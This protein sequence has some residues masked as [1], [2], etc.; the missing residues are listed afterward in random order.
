VA[1]G[2]S[3][4]SPCLSCTSLVRLD[5]LMP[6]LTTNSSSQRIRLLSIVTGL[7]AWCRLGRRSRGYFSRRRA[8]AG[9]RTSNV[10]MS[11]G[12][13]RALP[14]CWI[15]EIGAG[16]LRSSACT[17][18]MT[19]CI[20]IRGTGVMSWGKGLT[21]AEWPR[22]RRVQFATILMSQRRRA[23]TTCSDRACT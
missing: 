11:K 19:G 12:R 3:C 20:R 21:R 5:G 23:F 15:E 10:S 16:G 18:S 6:V 13:F 17:R 4:A 8:D 14:S 9:R 1:V 7:V 22:N 2:E